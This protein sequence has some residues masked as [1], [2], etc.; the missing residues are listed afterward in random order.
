MESQEGGG[1]GGGGGPVPAELQDLTREALYG[2]VWAE[3]MLR[4]WSVPA[5]RFPPAIWPAYA[6]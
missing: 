4:V 3:P 1:G 6:A 2:L 5:S